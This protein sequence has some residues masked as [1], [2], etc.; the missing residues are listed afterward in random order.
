MGETLEC[1]LYTLGA[2]PFFAKNCLLATTGWNWLKD[3]TR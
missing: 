2:I 3:S 1:Q